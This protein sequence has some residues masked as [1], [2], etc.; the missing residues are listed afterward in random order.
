MKKFFLWKIEIIKECF[1]IQFDELSL[2]IKDKTI[3]SKG[4]M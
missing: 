3:T 4:T 1:L 2:G